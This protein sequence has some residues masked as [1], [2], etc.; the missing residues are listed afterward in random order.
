[1]SSAGFEAVGWVH[2]TLVET[3]PDSNTVVLIPLLFTYSFMPSRSVLPTRAWASLDLSDE[4]LVRTWLALSVE[5]LGFSL[6]SLS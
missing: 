4:S 5:F 3:S 1:M 6:L 2:A